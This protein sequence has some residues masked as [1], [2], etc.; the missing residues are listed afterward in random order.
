MVNL[1]P[2]DYLG[3]LTF[4]WHGESPRTASQRAGVGLGGASQRLDLSEPDSRRSSGGRGVGRGEGRGRGGERWRMS[5]CSIGGA[6]SAKRPPLRKKFGCF[7]C[8]P[9]DRCSDFSELYGAAES[10][11]GSGGGRGNCGQGGGGVRE[12]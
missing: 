3:C 5:E 12:G 2:C 1:R 6:S 10:R 9:A 8:K 11:S 4:L 7:L